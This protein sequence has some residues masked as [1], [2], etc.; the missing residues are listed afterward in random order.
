ME[1]QPIA[2]KRPECH[3]FAGVVELHLLPCLAIDEAA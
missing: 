1:Q 2:R 3:G